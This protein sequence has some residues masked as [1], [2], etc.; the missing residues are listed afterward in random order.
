MAPWAGLREAP[1][2]AVSAMLR[3]WMLDA[4]RRMS[5]LLSTAYAKGHVRARSH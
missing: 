3:D 5:F 1:L 4:V 2:E